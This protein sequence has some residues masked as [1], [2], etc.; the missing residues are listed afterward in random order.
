MVEDDPGSRT[1]LR[2]VLNHAGHEVEVAE[3][4]AEA[5]RAITAGGPPHDLV[6]LDLMLPDGDGAAV[7]QSLRAAGAATTVVVTTGV[8]DAQWLDRVRALGPSALLQ[9]PIRLQ[10]LM[11]FL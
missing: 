5:M 6:V 7:L 9:K 11:R 8:M 10:E 3:T 2:Y 4:L 1:A